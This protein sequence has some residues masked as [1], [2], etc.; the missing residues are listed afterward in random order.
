MLLLLLLLFLCGK[1]TKGIGIGNEQGTDVQFWQDLHSLDVKDYAVAVTFGGLLQTS[2]IEPSGSHCK[3]YNGKL[4][5]A[6]DDAQSCSPFYTVT[7]LHCHSQAMSMSNACS[8]ST[9]DSS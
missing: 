7:F 8:P 2:E 6:T 1:V 5:A 9:I 4:A 3:R